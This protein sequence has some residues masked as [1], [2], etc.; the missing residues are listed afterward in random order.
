MKKSIDANAY[1]NPM[2]GRSLVS[3]Y[4]KVLSVNIKEESHTIMDFAEFMSIDSVAYEYIKTLF[5]DGEVTRIVSLANMVEGEFNFLYCRTTG[6]THDEDSLFSELNYSVRIFKNFLNK[7]YKEGVLYK[8]SGY[9]NGAKICKYMLNPNIA[10]KS[11]RINKEC[12]K[13]FQQFDIPVSKKETKY[14]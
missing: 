5:N 13:E 4:G 9:I 7:L 10:R 12:I 11:R 14:K 2:T 1:I 3:D 8:L 6:L